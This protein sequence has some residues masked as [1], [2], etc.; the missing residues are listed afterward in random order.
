MNARSKSILIT[1]G[2]II[3]SA[4]VL[5]S[6]FYGFN[7]FYGLLIISVIWVIYWYLVVR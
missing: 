4:L 1:A 2:A 7:F 3:S 5:I 6:S